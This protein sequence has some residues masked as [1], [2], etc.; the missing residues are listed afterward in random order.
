M[1]DLKISIIQSEIYWSDPVSSIKNFEVQI[2]TI[3]KQTDLIVLPEMF[4]TGF[5]MQPHNCFETMDGATIQW[6]KSMAKKKDCTLC[7][8]LLIKENDLF[9]NRLI[10]MQ[11]D[12]EYTTY[13]KKH[14]FRL[15]GENNIFTGGEE[16]VIVTLKG[17]RFLLQ[18]C[19]DLRFPV[20]SR[21]KYNNGLYDYDCIVYVANWPASRR[22]AWRTLLA[23]RAIENQA[24]VIGVN[25]IGKDAHGTEH[26]GDSAIISPKGEL[27]IEAEPF[28][29]VVETALIDKESLVDFRNKFLTGADW[30][31]FEIIN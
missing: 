18:I 28:T 7:G 27:I 12:G 1:Q 13:N 10:W 25:R 2:S 9:Y 26:A 3:K 11:A 17:F 21:N 4:S 31:N 16:K 30:D 29:N 6:M 20:W 22:L 8:S 5:N 14:L 15:A 19:Y 24:Y 23:S